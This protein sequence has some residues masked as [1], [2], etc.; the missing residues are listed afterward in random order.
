MGKD[1][2]APATE[3]AAAAPA[4]GAAQTT[5]PSTE[6]ALKNNPAATP[7]VETPEQ[8]PDAEPAKTSDVIGKEEPTEPEPSKAPEKY[9]LKLPEDSYL[10]G[11]A[12]ERIAADARKQGLSNEEAQKLVDGEDSIVRSYREAQEAELKQKSNAWVGEIK[13]DKEMGGDGYDA[14]RALAN[15]ALDRFGTEPL[16]QMLVHSTLNLHP[17]VFRFF[18]RVGKAMKGDSLV[19]SSSTPQ[20]KKK[21][22]E[23]KFYPDMDE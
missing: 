9:D 11:S 2:N 1:A 4:Q 19:P 18:L 16:K 5:E 12:L 10:D 17:E 8:T 14:N 6:E 20:D 13:A 22:R 21:T 3:P 15:E 7:E 23:Q